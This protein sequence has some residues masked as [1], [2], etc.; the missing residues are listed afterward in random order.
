MTEG[1]APPPPTP[2]LSACVPP[3]L[4]FR[5]GTRPAAVTG[6]LHWYAPSL[7][8]HPLVPP[9]CRGRNQGRVCSCVYHIHQEGLGGL[10][11]GGC[12]EGSVSVPL[13]VRT[14]LDFSGGNCLHWLSTNTGG[15]QFWYVRVGLC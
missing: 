8:A 13:G 6:A 11:R 7:A 1:V 4:R 3:P 10:L 9:C 5:A 2:S 14:G 12:Y 15:K